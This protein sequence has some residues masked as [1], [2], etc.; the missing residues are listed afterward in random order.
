M[1]QFVHNNKH[2]PVIIK[3]KQISYYSTSMAID[4]A[5]QYLLHD[6]FL[7]KK[8]FRESTKA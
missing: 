8:T 6:R 7:V 2:Y 3:K 4:I 5:S 1:Q